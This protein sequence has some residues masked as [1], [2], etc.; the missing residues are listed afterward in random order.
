MKRRKNYKK[1]R[2][3]KYGVI[4]VAVIFLCILTYSLVHSPSQTNINQGFHYKAAIVDH[5]SLSEPNQTFIQTSTNI[6]KTAE[7]T[8]D[9]Y[10]GE[11]VTVDFYRNLPTHSYDLILLR[12]H[13]ALL[14]GSFPPVGLFTSEIFSKTKYVYEQL[15]NQL[16]EAKFTDNETTYFGII[17]PFVRHSMNGR[18]EN[19]IIILMGC[20]GLTYTSMAEAFIEKGAKVYISWSGSVLASHT[21]QA[22]T[23][24]LQHIV[25]EKQTINKAITETM[26]EVEPDPM[27]ESVLL[28]YPI[29][30]ENFIIPKSPSTLI[31]NVVEINVQYFERDKNVIGFFE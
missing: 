15:T 24:L 28:Y 10:K 29:E 27:Y 18:F 11:E 5:L 19:S 22:T 23:H 7:F 30:A 4:A 17:P 9:Y 1:R 21:D 14:G 31:I 3:L 20:D 8:V 16:V 6:L 2:K 25:T 26:A 12:V 13:S